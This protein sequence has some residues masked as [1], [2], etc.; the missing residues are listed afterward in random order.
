MVG[1]RRCGHKL[2]EIRKYTKMEKEC[3]VKL[4]I[5]HAEKVLGCVNCKKRNK[6]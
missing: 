3:L 2:K 5:P 6:L 1:C 4:G